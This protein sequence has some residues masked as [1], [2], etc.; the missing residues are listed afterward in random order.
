TD[1]GMLMAGTFFK[2]LAVY[3]FY[4]ILQRQMQKA[5]VSGAIKG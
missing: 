3:L 1:Y 4:T 2:V 5:L